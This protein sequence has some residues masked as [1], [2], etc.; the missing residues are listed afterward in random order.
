MRS[1]FLKIFLSFLLTMALVG[2]ISF[3]AAYIVIFANSH[4]QEVR[5]QDFIISSLKLYEEIAIKTLHESGEQAFAEYLQHLENTLPVN[6]SIYTN[7]NKIIYKQNK[8][9]QI[10][11]S[12]RLA[13]LAANKDKIDVHFIE[14]RLFVSK[15]VLDTNK[16]EK[17][18]LWEI[19]VGRPPSFEKY[20]AHQILRV[21]ITLLAIG[22]V[23][24]ILSSYLTSPII[25]LSEATREFASGNWQVRVG[26]SLGKRKDEVAELARNFDDMAENICALITSQKRLISDISHELRSPLARLNVALDLA[27]KRSGE[28]A[29]GA[30][31]RIELESERL[32]DLIEQILTLARLE[33]DKSLNFTE[34]NLTEL[35]QEVAEDANFEAQNKECTVITKLSEVSVIGDKNLLR[36]VL[37]NI[38]RNAIRHTKEQTIVQ[39]SL[40]QEEDPTKKQIVVEVQDQGEGVPE[41]DLTAIFKPFYRVDYAR[42]RDKGGSGLGLAIVAQAVKLHKGQVTAKNL[43][44]GGLSISILLPLNLKEFDK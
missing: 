17:I 18:F 36:S 11:N 1:I 31:D 34:I 9:S 30:L 19:T 23:C 25:K 6:I 2:A 3:G 42:E 15:I 5:R 38:L 33:S 12:K 16:E 10:D 35:I 39:V 26:K 20:F 44:S 41:S 24:Y 7:K 29:F 32:N 22:L 28:K 27:R 40:R 14:G 21:L 4:S 37:D 8:P 13:D 43:A